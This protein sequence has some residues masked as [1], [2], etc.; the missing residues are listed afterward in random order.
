[1]SRK[2]YIVV[3]GAMAAAALAAP[4][5]A[6]ASPEQ[7]MLDAIDRARQAR[8]LAPLH[9]S[10]T[11]SRSAEG[12]SRYM[13]EADFFGHR[14]RISVP[15]K[16]SHVGE[17]L[18]MTLG[19]GP[20]V[21]SVLSGWLRSPAHRRVLLSPVYREAGVGCAKGRFRGSRA[22]AWTLHVGK[23]AGGKRRRHRA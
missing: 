19:G 12:Y 21:G 10:G 17:N 14:A 9:D 15:G 23:P 22:T 16:W 2:T 4:S 8:G 6:A 11:L 1:M 18:A 5:S 20:K 7:Q 13:L 3:L